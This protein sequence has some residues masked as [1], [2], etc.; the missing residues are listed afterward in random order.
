MRQFFLTYGQGDSPDAQRQLANLE[1]LH[2]GG[3]KPAD[4]SHLLVVREIEAREKLVLAQQGGDAEKIAAAKKDLD[5]IVAER[6]AVEA[7]TRAPAAT[8]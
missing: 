8:Q 2:I 4:D 5:G 3:F 1:L 7:R 6:E